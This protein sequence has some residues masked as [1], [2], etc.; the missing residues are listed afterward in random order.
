MD[1]P[2]LIDFINLVPCVQI[3]NDNVKPIEHD[4]YELL[5]EK[6]TEL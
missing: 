3:K 2:E 1:L 6:I 4:K 5:L